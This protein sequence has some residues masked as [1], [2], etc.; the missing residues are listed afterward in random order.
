M[1]KSK[2]KKNKTKKKKN[3]KQKKK[4][5]ISYDLTMYIQ[6]YLVSLINMRTPVI[7]RTVP[8]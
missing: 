7:T 3:K 5:Q 6:Q 4:K 8:A 2:K 1:E